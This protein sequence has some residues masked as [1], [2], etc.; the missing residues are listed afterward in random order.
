MRGGGIF[1]SEFGLQRKALDLSG[2]ERYLGHEEG[3][4]QES[5]TLSDPS[6]QEAADIKI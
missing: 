5:Q 2:T 3:L 4:I 1:V 6:K